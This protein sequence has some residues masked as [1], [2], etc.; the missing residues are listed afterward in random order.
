[1]ELA[2]AIGIDLGTTNS[3]VAVMLHGKVEVIANEQG[4][5]VTPSYVA[6][7]DFESFVD[8]ASKLQI[9]LNPEN[10]VFDAKRFIDRK[11]H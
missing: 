10:S 4:F 8:Y 6:F 9:A 3:C 7:D 11:F 5:F 2:L 1:M